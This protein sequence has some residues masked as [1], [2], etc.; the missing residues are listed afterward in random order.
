M[1]SQHS[2]LSTLARYRTVLLI[3]AGAAAGYATYR[4]L[5]S[6]RTGEARQMA[7]I[8]TFKIDWPMKDGQTIPLELALGK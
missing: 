1:S 8:R 6:L 7:P 4:A 2:A 5:K 3:C